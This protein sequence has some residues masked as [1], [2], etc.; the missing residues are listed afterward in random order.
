MVPQ[1]H[2][3]VC[4]T[5]AS[6]KRCSL[7]KINKTRCRVYYSWRIYAYGPAT[8]IEYNPGAPGIFVATLPG[9]TLVK[10]AAFDHAPTRPRLDAREIIACRCQ[11]HITGDGEPSGR[12]T[13]SFTAATRRRRNPH[14]GE[15]IA[16]PPSWPYIGESFTDEVFR[17]QPRPW[18]PAGLEFAGNTGLFF[19]SRRCPL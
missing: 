13:S 12:E 2:L 16:N 10:P 8:L 14:H 11:G 9:A 1:E 6:A 19:A 7:R 5:K 3:R 15:D 4:Q 18:N 17:G